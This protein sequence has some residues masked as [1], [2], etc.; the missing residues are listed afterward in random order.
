MTGLTVATRELLKGGRQRKAFDPLT[1]D[2]IAI[3]VK[4][5]KIKT[6]LPISIPMTFTGTYLVLEILIASP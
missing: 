1:Q 4:S 5:S 6:S 2:E 3:N